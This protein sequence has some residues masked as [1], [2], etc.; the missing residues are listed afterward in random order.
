MGFLLNDSFSR[1]SA[2]PSGFPEC[3]NYPPPDWVVNSA[4]DTTTRTT[5]ETATGRYDTIV[6]TLFLSTCSP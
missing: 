5:T 1:I 3:R 6:F 2:S 4:K